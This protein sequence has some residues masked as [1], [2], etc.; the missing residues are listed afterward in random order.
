MKIKISSICIIAIES[1]EIDNDL[2]KFVYVSKQFFEFSGSHGKLDT[3]KIVIDQC[4][5]EPYYAIDSMYES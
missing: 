1:V 4:N 5:P 2:V 3:I